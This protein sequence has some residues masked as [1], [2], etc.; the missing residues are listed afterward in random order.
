MEKLQLSHI[1]ARKVNTL[2]VYQ[3][4][5]YRHVLTAVSLLL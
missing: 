3:M 4:I 5:K 2:V 1:A